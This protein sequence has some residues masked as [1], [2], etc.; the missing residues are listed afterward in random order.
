MLQA[1]HFLAH[2][3]PLCELD[4]GAPLGVCSPGLCTELGEQSPVCLRTPV[5]YSP[6]AGHY[7][8]YHNAE[9][10]ERAKALSDL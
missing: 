10:P 3:E 2:M 4:K 1:G 8:A 6:S 9:G 5:L 7:S